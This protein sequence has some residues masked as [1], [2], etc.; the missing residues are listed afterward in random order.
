MFDKKLLK[1]DMSYVLED[2]KY[3][4]NKLEFSD[5]EDSLDKLKSLIKK[6]P[7][8][9]YFMINLVSPIYEN[10]RVKEFLLKNHSSDKIAINIGSGNS[11]ISDDVYNI[12]IFAYDNVD[13]VCDITSLPLKDSSVDIVLNLVVLEHVTDP[14]QVLKEIHRVLK[15]GGLVFTALPFIQ[16]FHAS[17][18]DFSRVTQEGI[19]VWHKDFD[20]LEVRPFGGPTSAILNIFQEYIPMLFS[21]GNKKVHIVIYLITMLCTFPFKFLDYFLIR[22]PMSKNI[23]SGFVYIGKKK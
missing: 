6:Y 1:E 14:H 12:D 9:Y 8:I 4:F 2:N 3:I 21:F 16:G 15:P 11:V 22:H 18:Y 13:I 17:P 19:K 23:S 5:I 20:K 10:K 7:K